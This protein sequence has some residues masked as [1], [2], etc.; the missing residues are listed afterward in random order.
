MISGFILR[1]NE[2][3][4]NLREVVDVPKV[5]QLWKHI[6][7]KELFIGV[8]Y[9]Y[10]NIDESINNKVALLLLAYLELTLNLVHEVVV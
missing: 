1:P 10:I 5:L 8:D 6:L 4:N 9:F 7:G 3:L 2:I